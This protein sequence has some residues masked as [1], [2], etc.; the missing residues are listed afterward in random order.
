MAGPLLH[1]L[2]PHLRLPCAVVVTLPVTTT[3]GHRKISQIVGRLRLPSRRHSSSSSNSAAAHYV[4]N[5]TTD[6]PVR[7]DAVLPL[8]TCHLV[9]EAT[10]A[11][12]RQAGMETHVYRDRTFKRRMER[13]AYH[14]SCWKESGAQPDAISWEV[15]RH[16]P[17]VL[18][19][20]LL[21]S[22]RRITAVDAGRGENPADDPHSLHVAESLRYQ[23]TAGDHNTLPF[24]ATSSSTP[25]VINNHTTI[26]CPTATGGTITRRRERDCL[27][28]STRSL[29]P[30]SKR[31]H[32]PYTYPGFRD[33]TPAALG[34]RQRTYF[35]PLEPQ[36]IATSPTVLPVCAGV[37]VSVKWHVTG[38]CRSPTTDLVRN[39][40]LV[41]HSR[42]Q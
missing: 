5:Q 15:D 20:A 18:P 12:G 42:S 10:D 28:T 16:P 7:L 17:G 30:S 36:L 9:P 25:R 23:R 11:A 40:D 8:L 38:S 3:R 14:P 27:A 26:N 1:V 35:Q 19:L 2:L 33:G 39:P 4:G 6:H 13:P 29:Q 34:Q 31:R 24:D 21:G 22:S 32:A 37:D 41:R